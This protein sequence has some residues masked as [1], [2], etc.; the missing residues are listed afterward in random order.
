M[1]APS[2]AVRYYY[3]DEEEDEYDQYEIIEPYAVPRF[4]RRAAILRTVRRSV[5]CS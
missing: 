1:A 4:R 2:S 3:D 5:H